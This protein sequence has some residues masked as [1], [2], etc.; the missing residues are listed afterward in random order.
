MGPTKRS[1]LR[2]DVTSAAPARIPQK[3]KKKRKDKAKEQVLNP[4]EKLEARKDAL[5]EEKRAEGS[6]IAQRHEN[7]VSCSS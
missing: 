6:A 7:M 4:Q 3:P 2:R 1:D 5:I